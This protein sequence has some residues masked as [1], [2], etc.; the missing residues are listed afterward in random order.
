M[1]DVVVITKTG[2]KVPFDFNKVD[3]A[4][5]KS[6]RRVPS[7]KLRDDDL[8]KIHDYISSYI[9]SNAIKEVD[10]PT[11]HCLVEEALSNIGLTPVAESYRSYRNWK[12][13]LSRM[14]NDVYEEFLH[15]Y[16]DDGDHENANADEALVTTKRCKVSGKLNGEIYKKFFLYPEE[17]QAIVDGFYYIHDRNARLDTY[18]CCLFD[19]FNVLKG[20]F[21]CGSQSYSEPKTVD[22][23]CDVL[24]DVLQMAASQQY[25]GMSVRVDDG[26]AYYVEKSYDKYMKEYYEDKRTIKL[27]ASGTVSD[28]DIKI[29]AEES[30]LDR[31]RT[32]LRQ[33]IQGWEQKLNTVASSRGDFVFISIA[34]GL[35]TKWSERLVSEM[36]LRVRMGG[37][38]NGTEKKPVVFPKLIFLY[39]EEVHG[40]G[41]VNNDLFELA[42]QCSSVAMYPDYLSLSGDGYVAEMYKKYK[43]V[44]YP[45]GCRAFLSPWWERGGMHPADENDVPVFT[46]RFNLGAISLNLPMIY[47]KSVVE[48][49]DFYETLH[50]YLEQIRSLHKR[51]IDFLGKKKAS[52]S[53]LAFC[54]GGLYG[55]NLKPND[56]IAPILK[57]CTISFGITALHELQLLHNGK[58]LLEDSQ[59]ANEVVDYILDYKN[60]ITEEDG[61]LYALYGTP[62]ES[63]C[64]TQAKQFRNK[65]GVIKG[66]SDKEYF[67]NSFHLHVSEDVSGIEKQNKEYTLFHKIVGGHIQYVRYN[68]NYNLNAIRTIVTRAMRMGFYEGVNFQASHCDECGANFVEGDV[69]PV[70]GSHNIS[71]M[72]RVCGY[73]GY[74]RL[75]GGTRMNS[76]KLCELR[77]RVSM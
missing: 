5:G 8:I 50:Y 22:A 45:M 23:A 15:I 68:V 65:Y 77:D 4:I 35:G 24:G 53:P 74:T 13:E 30:V 39:D 20:G 51:T 31:I 42:L 55:G 59:F 27:I 26:M 62:A 63:L 40:E 21:R 33:G 16:N 49:L 71:T 76:A 43:K 61:I 73:L 54:E 9:H 34:F 1:N 69:C 60:R 75:N 3:A 11:M 36:L 12:I 72:S 37:Q 58:S 19:W 6:A 18:N 29:M 41:K 46:G 70:C 10:V 7:F 66:V 28:D 25:G 57:S 52:M 64:G 47:Q 17:V 67:T 32:E 2:A 44:V 56:C 14:M 38:G 48:G